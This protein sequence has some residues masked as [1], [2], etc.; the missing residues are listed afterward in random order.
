MR[1]QFS[2]ACLA[3]L[4]GLTACGG[5]GGGGDGGAV[6]PVT[7]P[8]L[9]TTV[10][11][12]GTAAVADANGQFATQAGD[13]VEI[14]PSEAA[15]WSSSG[16]STITLL[17]PGTTATKWSAQILNASA[18]A[19]T[20]TVSATTTA[21]PAR[22]KAT[23]L[24]VA[25]GDARNG[26]YRVYASNGLQYQLSLDFNLNRYTFTDQDGSHPVSDT[27]GTDASE[28]GSFFFKSDRA[29]STVN[30]SR[31]RVT[32]DAV[33]GAFPFVEPLATTPTYAVKPFIAARKLITTAAELDG[34]YNLFGISREAA[35][36]G[37]AITQTS[38]SAGGTV[39]KLCN[40]M[41]IYSIADCPSGVTL[42]YSVEPT[43]VSGVWRMVNVANANDTSRFVVAR[44]G[45]QN[46]YLSGGAS[47]AI[48]GR[49][50]MRIGVQD[51]PVWNV[52]TGYG[53]S[54]G[55]SWGKVNLTATGNTREVVAADGSTSMSTNT[56]VGLGLTG[57]AGLRFV[58]NS[59]PNAGYFAIYNTKLLVLVGGAAP[60]TTAGYL[61]INLLD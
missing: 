48:A 18:T 39:F 17:N 4:A 31:F 26:T 37:S 51:T 16:A 50:V 36:N 1:I 60:S 7:P 54:T 40:S 58:A 38:L 25:A 5:G 19:G 43:D 47:N 57:P 42:T 2:L 28:P 14:T 59:A 49:Y 35:G 33:V 34:T 9:T 12:N 10:K 20:Y 29:P 41:Q 24:A 15:Q 45:N 21:S 6:T 55:G 23:V 56:Y 30:V 27:F 13:T 44:I 32:T 3:A 46:V 22:T 8:A 53:G 11:I 61:Q 52:A